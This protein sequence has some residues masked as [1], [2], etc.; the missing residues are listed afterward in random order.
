MLA[1]DFQALAVN[2]VMRARG[3]SYELF[4]RRLRY[5]RYAARP[6]ARRASVRR[7]GW[8]DPKFKTA[9]APRFV[10]ASLRTQ[11]ISGLIFTLPI[12]ITFWI[13][14]WL[15][16][17]LERFILDPTADVINRIQ[18]WMRNYSAFQEI[19]LPDWWYNIASPALALVLLLVIL[20]GMGLF[21]RSWVYRTLEGFLLQRAHCRHHLQ[22]PFETS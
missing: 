10:L 22:A 13:V 20:Y 14:Y 4:S 3:V 18:A 11:L 9:R 8:R 7:C 16:M 5:A 19:R 15:F 2:G 6:R 21:V 12:V 17:T 1:P